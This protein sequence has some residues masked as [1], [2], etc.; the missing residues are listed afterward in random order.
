MC[1]R[2]RTWLKIAYVNV[3]Y[4]EMEPARS[5]SGSWTVALSADAR[6]SDDEH[7]SV[8]NM[9]DVPEEVRHLGMR[10]PPFATPDALNH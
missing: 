7:D 3:L 10:I 2:S 6:P 1:S 8:D 5:L 4:E 9:P